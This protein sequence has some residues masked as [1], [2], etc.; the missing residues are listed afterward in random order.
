ME[1][2]KGAFGQLEEEESEPWPEGAC[3][4]KLL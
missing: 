2:F 1:D 3:F 4:K